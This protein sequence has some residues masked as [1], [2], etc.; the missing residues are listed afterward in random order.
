MFSYN[1]VQTIHELTFFKGNSCHLQQ[2]VNIQQMC[3][4]MQTEKYIYI[5]ANIAS[6]LYNFVPWV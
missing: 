5:L 4:C 3:S 1:H 6:R 2:I